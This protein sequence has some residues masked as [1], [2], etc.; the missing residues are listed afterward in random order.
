LTKYIEIAAKNE[1]LE[2]EAETYQRE[3]KRELTEFIREANML[4]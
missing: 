3:I 2:R 4:K 1:K